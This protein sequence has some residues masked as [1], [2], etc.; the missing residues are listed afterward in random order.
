MY[1]FIY[2]LNSC[3]EAK[4]SQKS[5]LNH[6]LTSQKIPLGER[7]DKEGRLKMGGKPQRIVPGKK[8]A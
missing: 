7:E 5:E 2:L 8:K 6:Y 4:A 1:L 3:C